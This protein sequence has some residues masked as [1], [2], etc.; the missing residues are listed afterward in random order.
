MRFVYLTCADPS[1]HPAGH[2]PCVQSTYVPW[3]VD[4]VVQ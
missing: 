4:L 1:W 2:S 3:K